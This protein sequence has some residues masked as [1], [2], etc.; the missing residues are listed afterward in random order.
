MI[1]SNPSTIL[2]A[3]AKCRSSAFTLVE[4]IIVVLIIG[5]IAAVAVPRFSESLMYHRAEAA[6]K[7]IQV[8]L[9]LA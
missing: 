4:L 3:S 7:R 8:D 1:R 6:A 2:P 9:G 5:I